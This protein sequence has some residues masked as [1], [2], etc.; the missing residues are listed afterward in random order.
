M[1]TIIWYISESN[2][3]KYIFK[4]QLCMVLVF[5]RMIKPDLTITDNT[6]EITSKKLDLF[7]KNEE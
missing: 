6:R 5:F 3:Q 2:S 1:H 7:H 4:V